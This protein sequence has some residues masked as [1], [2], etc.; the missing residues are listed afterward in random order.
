MTTKQEL[1]V[2]VKQLAD[3][4]RAYS[5]SQVRL[6]QQLPNLAL[7]ADLRVSTNLLHTCYTHGFW[8]FQRGGL[9]ARL[10]VDCATGRIVEEKLHS[11]A[12]PDAEDIDVLWLATRLDLLD[13]A[14]V[15]SWLTGLAQED[16]SLSPE[17]QAY[18]D[19]WLVQGREKYGLGY[20]IPYTRPTPARLAKR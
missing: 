4:I 9:G 11:T 15:I 5:E 3:D 10:C 14:K 17:E 20:D 2:K 12:I 19:K 7:E 16:Q 18:H 1:S 8:D 13:A 6:W